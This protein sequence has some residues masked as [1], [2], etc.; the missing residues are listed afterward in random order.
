MKVLPTELHDLPPCP[1]CAEA[2]RLIVGQIDEEG[3]TAAEYT[4]HVTDGPMHEPCAA[5]YIVF[6]GG[7]AVALEIVSGGDTDLIKEDHR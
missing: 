1:C 6:T 5:F 2:S 3:V 7:T 4:V